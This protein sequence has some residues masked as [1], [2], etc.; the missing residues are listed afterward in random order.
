MKTYKV[1]M[2]KQTGYHILALW[3]DNDRECVNE[4][5]QQFLQKKEIKH[6]LTIL[7]TSQ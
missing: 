2:E 7:Y 5:F 4:E 6:Q 3:S 1:Y